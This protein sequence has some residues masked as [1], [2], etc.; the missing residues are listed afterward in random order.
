MIK[1]SFHAQTI[2]PVENGGPAWIGAKDEG[3]HVAEAFPPAWTIS[4]PSVVRLPTGCG[5][6]KVEI[7]LAPIR[8]A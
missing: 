5:T 6:A 2:D 8:A 1:L 7:S 4:S 3:I